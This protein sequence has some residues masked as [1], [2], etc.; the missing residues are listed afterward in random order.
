MS[1]FRATAS[2][3]SGRDSDLLNTDAPTDGELEAEVRPAEHIPVT[4]GYEERAVVALPLGD[5][6]PG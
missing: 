2:A 3:S 1:T 6:S 5:D 4:A